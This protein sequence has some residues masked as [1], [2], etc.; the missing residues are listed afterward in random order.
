MQHT[1]RSVALAITAL[2][3]LFLADCT[4][5]IS[6]S[7]EVPT[8]DGFDTAIIN[9]CKAHAIQSRDQ[10]LIKLAR[11]GSATLVIHT[12]E[13]IGTSDKGQISCNWGWGPDASVAGDQ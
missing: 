5:P 3:G 9:A 11:P 2:A 8:G 10:L 1:G 12:E 4:P 13:V 7:I 6:S